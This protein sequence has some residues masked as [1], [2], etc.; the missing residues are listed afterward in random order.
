MQIEYQSDVGRRRNTNQDY[1]SVFTNQEGIKL[2]ILADG[3]GGHRAGD[4]ASQMAVLNLGNAWEEQ[5]LTDDEKIAQWFIQ[6]IQEE[7]ALIYQ[8]GQEQPEYNGMGTTIVA[9]ALSE[10]R[11]TIAHVGDSRAY[12]IRDGKIIQLTEDHS[13]VN[14]LVKSGEIS[15]EMAV[16]H[17]RKNILTRS[18][19][20]PGTVEVDVSTYIWQLKDRLLLCSDGL[21][22]MLSEEMI[23]TIVNQEGTLS[24]KVTE[25]IN[26]ANEAGGADNITVLLIEFKED[27]A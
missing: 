4:I 13:L 14:E 20:M 22:N 17:P 25:L 15:E 27:A 21:T 6:A 10:E 12:L 26:Q 3:M 9:A 1:A 2:A 11:F 23:E 18:V 19:G 16:N 5:D 8:R 7:N 24:D